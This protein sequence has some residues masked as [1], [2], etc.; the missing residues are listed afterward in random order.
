[1][2]LAVVGQKMPFALMIVIFI[3]GKDDR[4]ALIRRARQHPQSQGRQQRSPGQ[5]IESHCKRPQ[6]RM[7]KRRELQPPGEAAGEFSYVSLRRIPPKA[8]WRRYFE[9]ECRKSNRS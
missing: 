1:M 7:E 2:F 3:G 5:A 8:N 9:T 6:K 4:R